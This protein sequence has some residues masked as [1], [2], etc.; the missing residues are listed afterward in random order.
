MEDDDFESITDYHIDENTLKLLSNVQ[1]DFFTGIESK[2]VFKRDPSCIHVRLHYE[3]ELM[4]FHKFHLKPHLE[5]IVSDNDFKF[6]FFLATEIEFAKEGEEEEVCSR[7]SSWR[8]KSWYLNS[9]YSHE[10]KL[11]FI[12]D[13]LSKFAH[14]SFYPDIEDMS[15]E[16]GR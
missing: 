11:Q 15:C 14:D 5:N 13:M 16:F 6:F 12:D 9:F 8:N 3:L 10:N 1:S 2:R 7:W 4:F